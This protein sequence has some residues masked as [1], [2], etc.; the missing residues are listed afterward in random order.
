M[1]F[2][3]N[4]SKG[5]PK[6]DRLAAELRSV[7]IE[8]LSAMCAADRLRLQYSVEDITRFGEKQILENAVASANALCKFFASISSKLESSGSKQTE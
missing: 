8:L 7:Q 3:W 5:R 4:D 2:S 6:V 1:V